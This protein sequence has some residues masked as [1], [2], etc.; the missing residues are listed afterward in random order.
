MLHMHMAEIRLSLSR[1]PG[2]DLPSPFPPS[3]NINK[4]VHCNDNYN[5]FSFLGEKYRRG[6][7]ISTNP[8]P[9]PMFLFDSLTLLP[10]AQMFID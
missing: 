2:S 1:G 7:L 6:R 8:R 4:Q 5:F 9:R 3:S 10:G